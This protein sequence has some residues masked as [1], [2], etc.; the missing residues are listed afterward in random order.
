MNLTWGNPSLSKDRQE[1]D[2]WVCVVQSVSTY[3]C[4]CVL[5]L[6]WRWWEACWSPSHPAA[7]SPTGQ[8]LWEWRCSCYSWF[9]WWRRMRSLLMG[10]TSDD[11]YGWKICCGSGDNDDITGSW[12]WVTILVRG[13]TEENLK[14]KHT[15]DL[16]FYGYKKHKKK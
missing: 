2:T 5:V 10:L 11:A 6:P 14:E 4:G 12:W 16:I 15:L 3:V 8:G 9:P 7:W 1:I 13:A